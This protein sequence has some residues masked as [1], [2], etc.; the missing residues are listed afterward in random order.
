MTLEMVAEAF[1]SP[2]ISFFRVTLFLVGA[3]CARDASAKMVKKTTIE[4]F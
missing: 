1:N 3:S 2:I 4:W